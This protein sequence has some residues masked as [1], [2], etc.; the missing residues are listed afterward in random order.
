MKIPYFAKSFTK[1]FKSVI[2]K[3]QKDEPLLSVL[4]RTK[5]GGQNM[6]QILEGNDLQFYIFV[7]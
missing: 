1:T 3:D 2:K 5:T 4:P 6:Y 7:R